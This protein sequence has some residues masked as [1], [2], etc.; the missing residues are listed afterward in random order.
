MWL[1]IIASFS[2]VFFAII[3]SFWGVASLAI[4]GSVLSVITFVV[5]YYYVHNLLG[6]S[7]IMLLRDLGPLLFTT[8]II[9]FSVSY[10]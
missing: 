10:L 3:A 1:G 6:Y 2:N 5:Y 7:Y 9:V 8:I 4:A